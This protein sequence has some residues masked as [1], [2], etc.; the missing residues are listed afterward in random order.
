MLAV[1]RSARLPGSTLF[2]TV[3]VSDRIDTL[4]TRI[5]DV[6]GWICVAAAALVLGLVYARRRRARLLA[7]LNE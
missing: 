3:E 5:G 2:A 6:L 4:Y 1:E 7:S